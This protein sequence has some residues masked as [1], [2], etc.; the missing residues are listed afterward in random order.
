MNTVKHYLLI[1][2]SLTA[3]A[4]GKPHGLRDLDTLRD[5][6]AES[7][8]GR[9]ILDNDRIVPGTVYPENAARPEGEQHEM[10]YLPAA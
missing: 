8:E 10:I 7:P 2:P 3:A 4:E 1:Y 5:I 6:P 9:A